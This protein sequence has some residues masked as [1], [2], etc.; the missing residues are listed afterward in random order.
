MNGKSPTPRER[1]LLQEAYLYIEQY[2]DF[3]TNS[4]LGQQLHLNDNGIC[5]LKHSLKE[6]A[7]IHKERG[8]DV[9]TEKALRYLDSRQNDS[10]IA[11]PLRVRVLGK[12]QAGPKEQD[13]MRVVMLDSVDDAPT[14]TIP[15]TGAE[16][17][18]YALQVIGQS[19]EH[20]HVFDGDYVIVEKF[21]GSRGPKQNEMIVTM[22]LP[23]NVEPNEDWNDDWL[24]GPTVK[25]YFEMEEDGK[26]IYRLS[27]LRD[28]IAS[29][30]TIKTKY[31]KPVGRVIG[32]YRE[33]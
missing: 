1:E 33:I 4:W 28:I 7:F 25:F 11:I 5:N 15:H 22:Y 3:P 8:V 31:V 26:K 29:P 21:D 17:I 24:D 6:K 10:G 30:Y 23:P 13:Q 14:I 20:E 32:V 2:G 27:W 9:L 19:M 12:V 16:S 18:I